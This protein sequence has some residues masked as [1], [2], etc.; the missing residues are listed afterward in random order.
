MRAWV[1]PF[2][3]VEDKSSGKRRRFIAWPKSKNK[4]EDY[5]PDVPRRHVSSYLANVRLQGVGLFDLKASFYQISLDPAARA[6]FRM[7]GEDEKVYELLR[8]PMG[9]RV[10]PEL[11]QLLCS[12]LAGVPS[13]VQI[14]FQAPRSLHIDVWMDNF[15][16][17]S[18]SGNGVDRW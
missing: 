14:V 6:C 11:M 16:M 15:R 9:Y 17:S 4:G 1:N 18:M 5:V 12:A 7:M 8:L 10:S 2:S 3:V 13:V